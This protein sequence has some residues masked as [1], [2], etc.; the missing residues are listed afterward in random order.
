MQ[1]I[2]AGVNI[3]GDTDTIAAIAGGIC[4]ALHGIE[5]L[6]ASLVRQVEQVNGLDLRT[7]AQSLLRGKT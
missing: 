4:G 3:G 7:I 1:A 2:F 5:A 6:D